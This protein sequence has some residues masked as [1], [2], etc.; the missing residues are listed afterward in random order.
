MLVVDEVSNEMDYENQVFIPIQ[1]FIK[2][3]KNEYFLKTLEF[4]S[5]ILRMFGEKWWGYQPYSTSISDGNLVD[6]LPSA[7]HTEAIGGPHGVFGPAPIYLGRR[8]PKIQIWLKMWCSVAGKA[9]K[10]DR[11]KEGGKE[12]G[13]EACLSDRHP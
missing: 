7:R 4:I 8:T 6:G 2:G 13:G 5:K 1:F 3:Q 10:G 9:G 11:G 12:G